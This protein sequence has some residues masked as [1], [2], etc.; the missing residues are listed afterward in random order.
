MLGR[1][2]GSSQPV[3][4]SSSIPTTDG[5]LLRFEYSWDLLT[6]NQMLL[7]NLTP[8]VSSAATIADGVEIAG[9]VIIEDGVRVLAGARLKGNVYLGPNTFVGNNASVRGAT[10]VGAGSVIGAAADALGP[11]DCL[12][13]NAS[14]F[15]D[16][17]VRDVTRE[18]WDAHM[19]T[20][21]RAPFVLTQ[22]LAASLPDD[23]NGNVVNIL[24][25]RVRNLTPHFIS[26]TLSKA[27]LWTLTQ[28]L[29]LAL[30]LALLA[31]GWNLLCQAGLPC[32]VECANPNLHP[33]PLTR[34]S[35]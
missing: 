4:D 33:R 32:F 24:D 31:G 1:G 9:N 5:R 17:T 22:A 11:V 18:S 27:G 20:N 6:I 14:V 3:Y 8:R 21:L 16:D 13:N 29:A 7:S 12:I 34:P 2:E 30:A 19:E 26:Y 28:T 15:E 10:S 25:E 23:R 35:H